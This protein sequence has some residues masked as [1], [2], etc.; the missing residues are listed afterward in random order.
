[1][2]IADAVVLLL[3]IA[4]AVLAARY[5]IRRRRKGLGCCGCSGCARAGSCSARS[6][7]NP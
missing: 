4:D 6:K 1:M 7:S 3:L 2:T 5:L